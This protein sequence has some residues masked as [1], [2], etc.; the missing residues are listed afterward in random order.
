MRLRPPGGSLQR[1]VNDRILLADCPGRGRWFR[2][3]FRELRLDP[4]G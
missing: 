1:F 4:L 2:Y 3:Q